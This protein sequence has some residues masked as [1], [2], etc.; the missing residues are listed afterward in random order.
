MHGQAEMAPAFQRVP[1]SGGASAA[2]HWPDRAAAI[3]SVFAELDRFGIAYCMLND[4][5][6]FPDT[7]GSDI[8]CVV[9]RRTPTATL[10]SAIDAAARCAGGRVVRRSGRFFVLDLPVPPG[11]PR[12]VSL[13]FQHDGNVAGIT[14]ID[15]DRLL[16][17]RR[18]RGESWVPALP[19]AFSG[20]LMRAILKRSL[21]RDRAER[22]I[23]LRAE[24]PESCDAALVR[25]C[26]A[27][28]HRDIME[29]LRAARPDTLV[30]GAAR[31]RPALARHLGS[32]RPMRRVRAAAGRWSGRA[33]RVFRPSGL[34]VVLLGPDGAGKSTIVDR[35]SEELIGPF[36]RAEVRSF[37]PP[38]HW[39]VK[40]GPV[41][42]DQ[43]HALPKRS[44]AVSVAR[45]G[46]WLLYDTVWYLPVLGSMARGGLV[47]ND[48]HFIDVLVDTVRYRYGGPRWVLLAIRRLIPRPHLTVLLDAP[49]AVLHARKP[50]MTLAE[51][52]RQCA[53]Y[54]D[55]IRTIPNA[56]I[57]DAT[58]PL[59]RVVAAVGELIVDRRL[60]VRGR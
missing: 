38:L 13:D 3:H 56:H 25:D 26:P 36:D 35:L 44:V 52:E 31:W 60:A 58:M 17:G 5:E 8:D 51:T 15:G 23:A 46:Y 54:R 28:L 1:F 41:R 30:A 34:H 21:D 59:D 49:A 57:V 43:P 16:R 18:R 27:T 22:L 19:D 2:H 50:E 32:G 6:R 24:D 12:F 37:A 29:A 47:L 55:L 45:A 39:L 33:A 20:L 14:Y 53:A 4:E 7:P 10:A 40:R 9:D 48:R 42:T 11:Q